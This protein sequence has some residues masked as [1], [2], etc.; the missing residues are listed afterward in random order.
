MPAAKTLTELVRA[1]PLFFGGPLLGDPDRR[2][3]TTASLAR[4][5]CRAG[6]A[7]S[8]RPS[9][10]AS[11]RRRPS[12]ASRF[13]HECAHALHSAYGRAY[14]QRPRRGFSAH[15]SRSRIAASDPQCQSPSRMPFRSMGPGT[16]W[17]SQPRL[18][19]TWD[20]LRRPA[21]P[22][23]SVAAASLSVSSRRSKP[24]RAGRFNDVLGRCETSQTSQ[25]RPISS[26]DRNQAHSAGDGRR[27]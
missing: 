2:H 14:R 7:T 15:Q 3:R 20:V 19:T 26:V 17:T 12:R 13:A 27:A 23:G 24:V 6:S 1:S 10:H 11:A 4:A 21:R 16:E 18:G 8:R 25:I 22:L 9:T 5:C